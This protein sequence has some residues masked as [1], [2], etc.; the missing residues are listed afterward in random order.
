MDAHCRYRVDTV[1]GM[2]A[3]ARDGA[4]LAV[5]PCYVADG[6][7]RLRRLGGIVPA[8]STDLWLL[9]HPDLRRTARIRAFSDF[10]AD[11]VKDHRAR[12]AGTE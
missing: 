11:A 7:P 3:A 9:T 1:L 2:F 4:G 10:V 8:L 5:L 12:L 6:D